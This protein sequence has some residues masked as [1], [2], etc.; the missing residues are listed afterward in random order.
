MPNYD[1]RCP[2]G[3]EHEAYAERSTHSLSC[4]VC[5]RQAQRQLAVAGIMGMVTTPTRYAPIPQSR[6]M[7]AHGAL[8]HEARTRGV[9]P[10]DALAT[11]RQRVARGDVKAIE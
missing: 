11:A 2:A 7:E 8:L 10:P 9:E 1:W 3:H 6:F 4:P 5:N